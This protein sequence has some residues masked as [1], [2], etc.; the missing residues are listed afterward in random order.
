MRSVAEQGHTVHVLLPQHRRWSRPERDGDVHYHP[1][2]YSPARSWTPWGFSESLEGGVHI[3]K[4]LYALAPLVVGSAVRTARRLL[5]EGGFDLVHTHWVVPNGAIGALATPGHELPLVVSLHGSDVAVSERSCGIGRVTRWSLGRSTAVTAP[6]TDLLERARRLGA[7]GL[8]ERVPYGAD[9]AAFEVPAENARSLRRRLGF[10]EEHVVVAGVGRLIPVK[11]FEYLVAAHAEALVSAP[12]LR[13]VLVG[14]G[15]ARAA[16]EEQVSALGISDTVVLAGAADRAEIPAYMAAA[17][18]VAV[19]SVRY[20]RY[21]DGLPNVALE[22]MAAG[23]PLVA[24]DV[25]GLPELVRD[26]E[27]GLL[28]GEKDA[29]ALAGALIT[30]AGDPALRERLGAGG[31]SEIR[32]ERSWAEVGRRFVE[33]YEGA[34]AAH[35]ADVSPDA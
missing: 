28:V 7:R 30:L 31:Q 6:S 9:I 12:Q 4:P 27:N 8:L 13:L 1:Y 10:S 5:A 35:R 20:G 23:K 11:G 22:A 34:V 16:L 33:V 2:R 19:P 25:G 17:D 15:D 21:V 26:A 32:G 14:D 24:S 29:Q 18:V 3:R